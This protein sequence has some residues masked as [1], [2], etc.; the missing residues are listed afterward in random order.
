MGRSFLVL[1]IFNVRLVVAEERAAATFVSL[2]VVSVVAM[3]LLG[4]GGST[5]FQRGVLKSCNANNVVTQT[6]CRVCVT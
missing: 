6:Y 4:A 1:S 2:L 5:L 3:E